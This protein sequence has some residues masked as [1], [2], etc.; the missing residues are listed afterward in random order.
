[1]IVLQGAGRAFCSGYDLKEFAEG[2]F[3]TQVILTHSTRKMFLL[4]SFHP[5]S[6]VCL[7]DM[8]WDPLIDYQFMHK[9]T[10]DFMSL[11]RSLKPVICKIRGFAVAGGSDIAL[12]S[13]IV[14]MAEDAKIGYPPAALW[15]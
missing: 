3:G 2:S 4:G 7:K 8:P 10:E 11:W 13:D 12:C 1:V 5:H 15:V 14:V 6:R 9:N